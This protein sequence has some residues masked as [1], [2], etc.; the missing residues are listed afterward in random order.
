M[1][2]RFSI[3]HLLLYLLTFYY[4]DSLYIC[5]IFIR[6]DL[7]LISYFFSSSSYIESTTQISWKI[8]YHE[9]AFGE[10]S[11]RKRSLAIW[12]FVIFNLKR[13][14]LTTYIQLNSDSKRFYHK[15]RSEHVQHIYKFT[16]RKAFKG[17]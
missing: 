14:Q 17:L 2:E 12:L 6:V 7:W 15:G 9:V 13:R 10:F 8:S 4:Y 5:V 3:L 1:K 16:W 11:E